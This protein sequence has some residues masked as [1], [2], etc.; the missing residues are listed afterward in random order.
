MEVSRT[1]QPMEARWGRYP[2]PERRAE[3]R[4]DIDLSVT[5]QDLLNAHGKLRAARDASLLHDTV[6]VA[7]IG[8]R[9]SSE[10]GVRRAHKLPTTGA[11]DVRRSQYWVR[12]I[13]VLALPALL[14][15]C[16]GTSLHETQ[17]STVAGT[18]VR[19]A[20]VGTPTFVLQRGH[21]GAV[22]QA[23]FS[24]DGR[25][26][27]TIG[28][29][30]GGRDDRTAM[31]W[32]AQTGALRTILE[33]HTRR[34][35]CARFSPNGRFLLTASDDA[36]AVLWDVTTATLVFRI[37]GH[38]GALLNADFS[39]DGQ[40]I[41]TAS[42][43]GTAKVWDAQTGAQR[44]SLIAS[45]RGIPYPVFSPDGSTILTVDS[46]NEAMLWNAQTGELR[47]TLVGHTSGLVDA[48]FSPDSRSIYTASLDETAKVWDARTGALRLSFDA[49]VDG[50]VH[51]VFSP[52]GHLLLTTGRRGQSYVGVAELRDVQTGE[53]VGFLRGHRGPLLH[54]EFSPD[55]HLVVTTSADR[56]TKV[57]RVREGELLSSIDGHLDRVQRASFSPDGRRLVTASSD[58]TVKIWDVS[59][60]ALRA[61]LVGDVS[62]VLCER[63]DWDH[64][65]LTSTPPTAPTPVV[66]FS[67]N[68]SALAIS[69][70]AITRIVDAHTG[71]LLGSIESR[72][73]VRS[74]RFSV[75]GSLLIV[76][77]IDSAVALWETQTGRRRF[78]LS[79]WTDLY[80][81]K[82]SPDGL[83][84]VTSSS[85]G[86]SI[87]SAQTGA[88]RASFD[89]ER[90]SRAHVLF[91]P[92]GRT[93][94]AIDGHGGRLLNA[95]TGVLRGSLVGHTGEIVD[96]VFSP[97]GRLVVTASSDGTA[98]VWNARSGELRRTLV[99]H[100]GRVLDVDVNPSGNTILT[101]G[102]DSTARL[103]DAET[104]DLRAL[105]EGHTTAVHSASYGSNGREILTESYDGS[106]RLWNATSGAL[107]AAL[108]THRGA[109]VDSHWSIDQRIMS[110][111]YSSGSLEHVRYNAN[112]DVTG[113]YAVDH[114]MRGDCSTMSLVSTPDGLFT[115]DEA[116]F[117][118]IFYRLGPD[119]LHDDLVTADQLFEHFHRSTLVEDF[120]SNRP[121]ELPTGLESGVG[122]PPSIE[123][124][125]VPDRVSGEQQRV[126][127][128]RVRAE[129]RGGG[130]GEVRVFVNGARADTLETTHQETASSAS[131]SGGEVPTSGGGRRGLFVG[132]S[133]APHREAEVRARSPVYGPGTHEV[134]VGLSPGENV[135][136]AEGYSV[137]G[138]VRGE[139]A[140]ATIRLDG[141]PDV[142][143]RLFVVAVAVSDYAD[144]SL[145]LTFPR[146]DAESIEAA[147]RRQGGTGQLFDEVIPLFIAD[148]DANRRNVLA[149]IER[150]RRDA[151]PEDM[152]IFY[153]ASHGV[154]HQCAGEAA[155]SYHLILHGA[156]RQS[157]CRDAIGT[158]EL[159]R[160]LARI[161][162]QEK[163][164]L[165]DTC[166]SGGAVDETS[167]QVLHGELRDEGLRVARASGVAV[168]SGSAASQS[169]YEVDALGHGLFTVTLLRGLEGRAAL[170][171][172]ERGGRIGVA[173]LVRYVS[174]HLPLLAERYA[175]AQ[176]TPTYGARGSDFTV[177]LSR[178]GDPPLLAMAQLPPAMRE[179]ESAAG[180]GLEFTAPRVES[181][182]GQLQAHVNGHSAAITTCSRGRPVDL[183]ARWAVDGQ[184]R[185]SLVGGTR[186]ETCVRRALGALRLEAF[187]NRS[188]AMRV[189]AA[190]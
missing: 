160:S 88:L 45:G 91:G 2:P 46:D 148:G 135:I 74:T 159:T 62:W 141:V 72:V 184:V 40:T 154:V 152:V 128:L 73:H 71:A 13:L 15:A 102:D 182:A 23:T 145:D 39:P 27:V 127:T 41:L 101:A 177:A 172:R 56:T 38:T 95:E 167:L 168:I 147:L 150:V 35:T 178:P 116:A 4:P 9:D 174:R 119:V 78:S 96:A 16:G 20:A 188:G 185:F 5:P 126:V 80:D 113:S 50:F 92:D 42:V 21:E 104:G 142:R 63:V 165:L 82:F 58:R 110:L 118:R 133:E 190:P 115:G 34:V 109:I 130:V 17:E 143:R 8:A 6:G 107:S 70:G 98:K 81:A 180:R 151:R 14:A 100:A 175:G 117:S 26:I 87:W 44:S 134:Q 57:W 153:V 68:G 33:G 25:F 171:G 24:T 32:D 90:L 158:A 123:L 67:P 108:Q 47:A 84:L 166:Q 161:P 155:R 48:T 22:T 164:L 77:S 37:E 189:V 181:V 139:R 163:L 12:R 18:L 54:T 83:W 122:R 55:G 136:T 7:T 121:L 120:W 138:E 183:V 11:E 79:R 137:L 162:A 103:W 132:R 105:L 186:V 89:T 179:A 30:V 97:D 99:G 60:G 124:L 140:R 51:G 66:V 173:N 69:I 169:S 86:I 65:S 111:A 52:D 156:N 94:L 29:N 176:Q 144:D 85:V 49:E 19:P 64:L 3:S 76:E 43:D 114:F 59:T 1:Q 129:D 131:T 146:A 10:A 112:F 75:D 157:V 125:D 61:S 170:G 106:V 36:T 31:V 93:V 149:A 53:H 187:G 28:E